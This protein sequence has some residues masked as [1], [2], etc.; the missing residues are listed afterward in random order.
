MPSDSQP[1]SP[2]ALPSWLRSVIG[3]LLATVALS[4]LAWT[5]SP[6]HERLDALS[7]EALV[8]A[9]AAAIDEAIAKRLST[10]GA[11]SAEALDLRFQ[12]EGPATAGELARARLDDQPHLRLHES[13]RDGALIMRI[14]HDERARRIVLRAE[15]ADATSAEPP[16]LLHEADTLPAR[17]GAILAPL[18]AVLVAVFTR[19]LIVALVCAMCAGAITWAGI[20][21]PLLAAERVVTHYVGANLTQSFNLY[22]LGFTL[23]LVG[24]VHVVLRMGGMAGVLDKLGRFATSVRATRV[25]TVLMGCALFFDDYANTIVVGSTMRP[26]TDR[27]HISREKLA[28]LV[29]ATSAPIAGVAIISTWIGFEVGLFDELSKQLGLGQGGYEIVFSI[30]GYR[31]YCLLTLWFVLIN[32]WTGRD[33]GPMRRAEGRARRTGHVARPGSRLLSGSGDE[34]I[35]PV[36]GA[37]PRWYNAAIPVATVLIATILGMVWSGWRGAQGIELPSLWGLIHGERRLPIGQAIVSMDSVAS[38]REA[39]SSADNAKVL[40]WSAMGAS[41]LAIVLASAQ[42]IMSP[43]RAVRAWASAMPK[44]WMAVAIFVLAWA[45]RSVCEDL[46]TSVYL[47]GLIEG[48]L[49]PSF[50]PLVTF[51]LASLVALATGTSW[52][53]MG[54]LLPAMIPLAYGMSEGHPDA[55]IIVLLCFGAVLDGAIFGDHCSPVSDTTVMSSIASGCDHV[56]HVRTQIPYAVCVMLASALFGYVGVAMG[57]PGWAALALGASSLVAALWILG[58]DHGTTSG[59]SSAGM[60]DHSH[61][62]PA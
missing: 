61:I 14:R 48:L 21:H 27:Q 38:W 53:T 55:Q 34:D 57:L 10:R 46:G 58:R 30:L 17:W 2:L 25:T 19:R 20:G 5:A 18:I 52:G 4:A 12:Y 37:P 51:V 42:R 62:D 41:A 43:W 16:A 56:D 1:P 35:E 40:F 7:A 44:M 3:A 8:R 39:F 31:F 60:D 47:M 32:A 36:E 54:I 50:L 24:M 45:I 6:S 28:F 49:T 15:I 33:F 23:S 59:K 9:H 29:D 11:Q 26:V 13:G 22:V